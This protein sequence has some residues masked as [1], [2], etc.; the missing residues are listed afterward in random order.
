M[1]CTD[2]KYHSYVDGTH[3]CDSV[4]HKRKTVRISS[5]ETKKD[6]DCEWSQEGVTK[7]KKRAAASGL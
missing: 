5:E 7:W 6:I 1:K 3:F 4:N 2:C